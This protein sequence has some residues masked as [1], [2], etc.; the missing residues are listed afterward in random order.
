MDIPIEVWC[1]A[2]KEAKKMRKL[3]EDFYY[4]NITPCEQRMIA[5][6]DL[7]QAVNKVSQ[8]EDQLMKCIDKTGQALH[9]ELVKTQHEIDS[10]TV[11]EKWIRIRPAT[12]QRINGLKPGSRAMSSPP[13]YCTSHIDEHIITK[14]RQNQNQQGHQLI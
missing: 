4:S 9:A 10:I 3:L 6:S 7:S 11:L 13:S 5:N 12:S 2:A 1:A 8:S 14:H